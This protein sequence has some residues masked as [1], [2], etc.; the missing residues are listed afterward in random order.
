MATPPLAPQSRVV[1]TL[2]VLSAR[3]GIP[4]LTVTVTP[5][6]A[7]RAWIADRCCSRVWLSDRL[8]PADYMQAI[9]DAVRTLQPRERPGGDAPGWLPRQ[10]G[11]VALAA[12]PAG[13]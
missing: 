3:R 9:R 8:S 7:G 2:A 6:T 13:P 5:H 12:G 11:S 10:R 4:D 1:L